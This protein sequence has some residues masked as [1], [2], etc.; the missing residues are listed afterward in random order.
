MPT[1]F[2]ALDFETANYRHASVCAVG[3]AV[4]DD[5]R[6]VDSLYR[7]IRPPKGC[8]WFRDDFIEIHGITHLDVLNEPEFPV[9]AEELL[10]RLASADIVIAHKAAF[11]IAKLRGSL[12][13]FGLPY[14][15]FDYLCT[16]QLARRV[17]PTLANH[18]LDT[19]VEHIGHQFQ[20]HHAGADAEAAGRV[21]LAMMKQVGVK[22]SRELAQALGVEIGQ[23]CV[24]ET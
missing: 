9:I 19:V 18:Q 14:P 13:H 7:L 15:Q 5:G 12:D 24:S 8:G 17:W 3:L 22:T 16:V 1:R 2:A 21:M 11:D 6:L 23:F 4:F 20:H 10:P